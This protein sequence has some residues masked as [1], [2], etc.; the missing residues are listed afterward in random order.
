MQSSFKLVLI[1]IYYFGIAISIKHK[2]IR[3]GSIINGI[4]EKLGGLMG[5]GCY[6]PIIDTIWKVGNLKTSV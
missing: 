6:L 4:I 1:L 2:D 3:S 5:I